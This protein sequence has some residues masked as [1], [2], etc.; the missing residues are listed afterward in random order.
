MEHPFFASAEAETSASADP[1]FGIPDTSL[2]PRPG[3]TPEQT[4]ARVVES[5]ARSPRFP[6]EEADRG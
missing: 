4:V 3:E 1:P 2:R 6:E 5:V